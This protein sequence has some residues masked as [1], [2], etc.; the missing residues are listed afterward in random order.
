MSQNLGTKA[1]FLVFA[2][3]VIALSFAPAAQ[4]DIITY[5]FTVDVPPGSDPLSGMHEDGS[6]SYDGSSITPGARNLA[7]DL[8][9]TLDFTV[10]GI[11]YNAGTANTG[12]LS[13]DAAGDLLGF[14]FGTHCGFGFGSCS[15]SSGTNNWWV[16][17]DVDFGISEFRYASPADRSGIFDGTVTYALAGSGP[18]SVPEPGTLGLFGLGAL[19]LGLFARTRLRRR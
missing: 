15:I 6:F 9:T 14:H 1:A 2:A 17:V 16:Y 3:A 18:I 5:N 19:M 12:F 13:F 4:A 7:I 8:L 11:T 10:S